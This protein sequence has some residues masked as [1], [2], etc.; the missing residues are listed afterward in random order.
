MMDEGVPKYVAERIRR[1]APG[2]CS[3]VPGTTPVVAFG[4]AH[5]ARVA[6]LGLNPS[7]IEFEVRGVELDG[8]RRRFETL[9]SLGIERL[10][11]AGD[12]AVAAVYARCNSYFS[13]NPYRRW[14]DRLEEVLAGA[15]AS[16]YDGTACHLDLSQWATDPTW[17]KLGPGARSRLV[18]QDAD[19]L[20]QQ[21]SSESIGLLLLNGRGVLNVYRDILGGTFSSGEHITPDTGA[22]TWIHT[23]SVLGVPVVG[24]SVNLQSSFGVTKDLRRQLRERVAELAST[25]L[26]GASTGGG[27]GG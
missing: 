9:R 25:A 6:T 15:G 27:Y 2:D 1:D 16:Y 14:F 26:A 19:F 18:A 24:W 4:P 12:D 22:S 7:R 20:R 5:T 21:L 8:Q 10:A 11:D 23:G 3:V 13:G 17:G